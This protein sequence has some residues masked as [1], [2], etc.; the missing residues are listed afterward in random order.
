[1]HTSEPD[2]SL[3]LLH[4]A[5]NQEPSQA[6]W[7]KQLGVSRTT[8]SVAQIR[9][10]LTPIVAADLARLLGESIEHWTTV[11]ALEAQPPSHKVAKLQGMLRTILYKS[12][13]LKKQPRP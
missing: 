1:M 9:G 4:K 12:R 6:F 5:L 3:Q 13:L 10:R 7:C 2:K 8:L 11:A